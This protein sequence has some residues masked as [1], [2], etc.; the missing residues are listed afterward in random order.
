[1][2]FFHLRFSGNAFDGFL[3]NI[4]EDKILSI[5]DTSGVFVLGT[6]NDTH[7]I[8][9]WGHS[10]IFFIGSAD[11]LYKQMQ[12]YREAITAAI[13]NH[14]K[15]WCYP[16]YQ[17]GAAFGSSVAWRS[18]LNGK[19]EKHLEADLIYQFYDRFGAIPVANGIWPTAIKPCK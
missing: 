15:Y 6:A 18:P 5:P 12:H 19:S 2:K 3:Q 11:N 13:E 4:L 14:E 9:P 16:R 10:P 7:L 1:M 17:Y 8:Y